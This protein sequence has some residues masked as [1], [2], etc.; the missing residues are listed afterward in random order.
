MSNGELAKRD[1]WLG[2]AKVPDTATGHPGLVATVRPMSTG[3]VAK[4]R[5]WRPDLWPLKWVVLGHV[6]GVAILAS[7]LAVGLYVVV[8]LMS[9]TFA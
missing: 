9:A 1:T 3:I 4:S 7:P 8:R 2:V 6:A 5:T